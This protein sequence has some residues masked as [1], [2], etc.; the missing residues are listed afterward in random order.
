VDLLFLGYSEASLPSLPA[1][2]AVA[3]ADHPIN[4]LFAGTVSLGRKVGKPSKLRGRESAERLVNVLFS[5]V[6]AA[7]T[8][9]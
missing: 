3:P 8:S 9:H 6:C 5:A 4:G 1:F 2:A 7:C